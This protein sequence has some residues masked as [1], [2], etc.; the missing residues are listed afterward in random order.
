MWLDDLRRTVRAPVSWL[1]HGYLASASVTLLTS[2]W[3]SGKTTIFYFL[4][5]FY[6]FKRSLPSRVTLRHKARSH[7]DFHEVSPIR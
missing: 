2:Q 4:S 1:W 7:K 3:K 6:I 5:L